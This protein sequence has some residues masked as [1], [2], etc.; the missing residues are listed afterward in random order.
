MKILIA[1]S[2]CHLLFMVLPACGDE[3]QR[4]QNNRAVAQQKLTDT[5]PEDVVSYFQD[6]V[7]S[8]VKLT[9]KDYPT[10]GLG[11]G[12]DAFTLMK[13][14]PG[15]RPADF[16]AITTHHGNYFIKNDTLHFEGNAASNSAVLGREGIKRLLQNYSKRHSLQPRSKEDVNLLL[17][18]LL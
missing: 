1:L 7:I 3:E 4:K 10:L 6:T 11:G 9:H 13:T 14:F 15:L 17:S 8:W 5:I 16:T 12:T 18:K 2:V